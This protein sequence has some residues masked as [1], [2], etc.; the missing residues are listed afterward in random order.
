[1]RLSRETV[2]QTLLKAF[3]DGNIGQSKDLTAVSMT[4]HSNGDVSL[5]MEPMTVRVEIAK[6]PAPDMQPASASTAP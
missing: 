2:M 3:N 6:R 4:F 1:M 5:V